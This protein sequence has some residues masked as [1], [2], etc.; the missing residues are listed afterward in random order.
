MTRERDLYDIA[1][2]VT[3]EALGEGTYA[4][5]NGGSPDPGV[6]AAITRWRQATEQP[7]ITCPECG[8]TSYNPNDIR[9]GYCGN[10]HTWTAP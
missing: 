6:R 3:D 9:E 8:M 5:M 1:L 10:C 2:E 7:S 4:D